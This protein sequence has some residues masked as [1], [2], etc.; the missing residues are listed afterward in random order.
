MTG[1]DCLP[2]HVVGPAL[3][4]PDWAADGSV[5]VCQSASI[6]PQ[7]KQRTQDAATGIEVRPVMLAID[8]RG[9]TIFLA[10]GVNPRRIAQGVRIG[11][12]DPG[13]KRF[14]R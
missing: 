8:A 4:E 6:P 5:P 13:W 7:H 12:A 11:L 14:R 1:G 10:D 3:P 2:A 9:S